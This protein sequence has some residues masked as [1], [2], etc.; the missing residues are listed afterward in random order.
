LHTISRNRRNLLDSATA[1]FLLYPLTSTTNH[2]ASLFPG[3]CN[4]CSRWRVRGRRVAVERGAG[5]FAA[6]P[7]S[8]N[9]RPLI[10]AVDPNN[11]VTVAP[12][13]DLIVVNR[14][15]GIEISTPTVKL[16]VAGQ[17]NASGGV[18]IATDCLSS[19]A[20]TAIRGT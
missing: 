2:P 7:P 19:W 9:G 15:V 12:A 16:D 4:D 17:V 8:E 6:P 13:A 14:N 3:V 10:T 5:T 11:Q 20:A 1:S 18:C